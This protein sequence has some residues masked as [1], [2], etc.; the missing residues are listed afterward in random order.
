LSSFARREPNAVPFDASLAEAFRKNVATRQKERKK[1][2]KTGEKRL[3]RRAE[4]K[5]A[6]KR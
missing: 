2:G 5:S 4:S 3:R 6:R 1:G